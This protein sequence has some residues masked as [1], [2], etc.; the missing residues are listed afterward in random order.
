MAGCGKNDGRNS[1]RTVV[2]LAALWLFV[3]NSACSRPASPASPLAS[4]PVSLTIGVPVQ[5]GEDPLYGAKQVSRL[6]NYE[7][8][9]LPGRDGRAQARLA[10]KWTESPDGL[11][12]TFYLRS[13]AFFHDGTRVDAASVKAS[14]ERSLK[15]VNRDRSPGLKDVLSIEAPSD[16][17][18]VIHLSDRSAFLLD[19]LGVSIE[20]QGPKG[21]IGTGPFVITS[22]ADNEL[23]MSSVKSY[24]R[25]KPEIDRIIWRS[26][27]ALRTAW[28]AMMRGE[29]DFLYEVPPGAVEFIEPEAT[30]Q[31]FPFIRNYVSLVIFNS[32]RRPFRDARVRNALN[33][34]IDRERLIDRAL[35]GRGQQA[36]GPVWPLHWAYDASVPAY[37]YDPSR[38]T[39]L[40]DAA[41]IP[42]LMPSDRSK[43]PGRFHFTC[44]VPENFAVWERMAL[45][46]Q[47]DL[48]AIG[49]DMQ[50]ESVPFATLN[51]RIGKGDFD[52]V[53]MELIVG[54]A[55]SRPFTFWSTN[56]T[57]NAW[58]Y[59]SPSLDKALDQLR[60]AP[61]ESAY[62]AAFR[63]VQLESLDDP[64][65]IFLA[66]GQV[67]RAVSK[68]F[69]V[70][71]AAGSD[72]YASLSDW[73]PAPGGER[74]GN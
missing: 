58:G 48:A 55:A 18:L 59:S 66:L 25:G 60:R 11:T 49:V 3:L 20:K 19:D 17:V 16:G 53:I 61:D 33:Y 29:I 41:A 8:L 44:L 9:T 52:A 62:R 57:E 35:G 13:N 56:S 28:A 67:T 10:E 45:I 63:Q 24:Y 38:A 36:S 69:Q 39:A 68:R 27:P 64:P 34:A 22:T 6:L 72:I 50:I 71:A 7:G 32:R 30:V 42:P 31:V 46:V 73:R 23:V 65:A 26:Y 5:T 47:R 37:S 15:S 54:N 51:E 12:W 14:L 1:G 70:V 74:S 4:D 40:L 21:S 2:C 43:A